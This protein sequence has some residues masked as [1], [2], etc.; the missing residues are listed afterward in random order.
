RGIMA[1]EVAQ[2]DVPK[3]AAPSL[4]IST[5]AKDLGFYF[6][7][8]SV[9]FIAWFAAAVMHVNSFYILGAVAVVANGPH[10]GSTWTRVYFDRRE[11]RER[12]LLIIG[13]PLMIAT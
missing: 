9:V 10:L 8:V 13:M 7:S 12:P 2:L 4:F 1:V 6:F 3:V 11:W 5:P